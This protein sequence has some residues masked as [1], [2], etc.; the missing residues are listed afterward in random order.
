MYWPVASHFFEQIRIDFLALVRYFF[1]RFP[2]KQLWIMKLL[3]FPR[4]Q[5]EENTQLIIRQLNQ[6]IATIV[7]SG[8]QI[9]HLPEP[10]NDPENFNKSYPDGRPDLVHLNGLVHRLMFEIIGHHV[11]PSELEN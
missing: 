5:W 2:D 8:L 3:V 7:R 9:F 10:V 4:V 1:C 11:K 6:F